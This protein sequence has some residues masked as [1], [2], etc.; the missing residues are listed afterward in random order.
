RGEVQPVR[1]ESALPQVLAK[2]EG[3]PVF[4]QS[5]PLGF[6]TI[7]KGGKPWRTYVLEDHGVRIATA[8]RID[9]REGLIHGFAYTIVLPFVLA[10]L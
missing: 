4:P 6:S 8:D 3:S 1:P 9:V 5:M 7:I 2:T 10:L